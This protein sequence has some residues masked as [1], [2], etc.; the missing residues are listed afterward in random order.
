MIIKSFQVSPA[1][2][3]IKI[4]FLEQLLDE[5]HEQTLSDFVRLV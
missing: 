1:Y 5:V 4:F 3:E 2:I